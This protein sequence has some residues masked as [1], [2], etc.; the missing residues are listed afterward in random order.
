LLVVDR[1]FHISVLW[2][3][4]LLASEQRD[5]MQRMSVVLLRE[6]EDWQILLAQVTPVLG[7]HLTY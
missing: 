3:D 7:Y 5:W 6:V 4:A 1:S 2:K